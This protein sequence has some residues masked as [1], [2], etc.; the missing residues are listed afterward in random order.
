[1]GV[2]RLRFAQ[3][4]NIIYNNKEMRKNKTNISNPDEL[5]KHLQHSSPLTW[6]VLFLVIAVIA[7]FFSWSAIYK[8]KIRLMGK[9]SITSGVVTLEIKDSDLNKL[10]KGQEVYI[11]DK[12]GEIL[13]FND[14]QPVIS[15]FELDDGDQ[16][17]YTIVL[18]EKRPIEF[19]IK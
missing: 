5:N 16:Y 10:K 7:A 13:S 11:L 6:I 15:K 19:L 8:L 17:T 2:F 3:S 4:N 18:E 1:M 12:K 14:K 9:A